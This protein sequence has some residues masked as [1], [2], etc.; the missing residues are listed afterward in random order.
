MKPL[1]FLLIGLAGCLAAN[2]SDSTNPALPELSDGG[3]IRGPRNEKR[4]ALVFTAHAFA[5]GGDTILRE[6]AKH[7]AKASFFV[8]GDFLD[9]PKFQPLAKRIIKEGHYLGP[10][11]DKHLLYCPWDGPKKTLVTR[12]EF[13]T[14]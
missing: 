4:L 13:E 5:E 1:Y 7:H 14:D 3:I 11:S 10:H 12:E 9:N 8:T 2:A 6:L